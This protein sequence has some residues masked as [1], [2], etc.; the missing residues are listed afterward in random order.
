MIALSL[1]HRK[2]FSIPMRTCHIALLLAAGSLGAAGAPREFLFKNTT[3]ALPTLKLS[4]ASATLPFSGAVDVP[5]SGH[6]AY[7]PATSTDLIAP[8]S[9][10]QMIIQ[11]FKSGQHSATADGAKVE[12]RREPTVYYPISRTDL[13][14]RSSDRDKLIDEFNA[15]GKTAK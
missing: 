8:A 14:G 13:V 7:F 4:S 2:E 1:V 9:T 12:V 15:R 10:R 11:D 3:I 6:P 5:P